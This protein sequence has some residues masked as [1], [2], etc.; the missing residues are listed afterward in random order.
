MAQEATLPGLTNRLTEELKDRFLKQTRLSLIQAE[1]DFAFEGQVVS[2]IHGPVAITSDDLA[3][4]ER[5]TITIKV[6]FRNRYDDAT[7]FDKTFSQ[8]AEYETTTSFASAESGLVEEIIEKLTED[9]FN[10][11]AANW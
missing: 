5:L 6:I 10:A 7:S 2:Y 4:K 9:I 8:Y 11:S 3:A 1:G